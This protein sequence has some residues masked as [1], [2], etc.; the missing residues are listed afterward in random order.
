M[1][2]SAKRAKISGRRTRAGQQQNK[3][4]PATRS[5]GERFP[6]RRISWKPRHNEP[7]SAARPSEAWGTAD[8]IPDWPR[9][10]P[11]CGPG[12]ILERM[13][14]TTFVLPLLKHK[15]EIY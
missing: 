5:Q 15:V 13:H 9:P 4:N 2:E 3:S 11:T 8:L 7:S 1:E 10:A 14:L 6:W 12:R